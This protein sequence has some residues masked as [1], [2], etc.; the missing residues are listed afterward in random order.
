MIDFHV[1]IGK[2]FY[3][4][5]PLTPKKLIKRMNEKGIEKAV[6]LPIENP[7]ETHWY[8]TSENVLK[9]CKK[10][11]ERLIPFCNVDPRRGLNNENE[12]FIKNLIEEYAESG[13]KG[14]G[15]ILANLPFND[16]RM[17]NIYK[18][19]GE[20]KLPIVFHLGGVPGNST[21]GLTDEIGLPFIEEVLSEFPNTIFVAHGPGWWAEISGNVTPEERNT[22]PKGKIEKEGKVQYL[23]Q[24]YSNIYAD[25]S[26][27]SAYNALTRDPEYGIEFLNKFYDKLLFATDYLY[28]EQELPIIDYLKNI[29]L[30]EEKKKKIFYENA[31]KLLNI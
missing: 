22:Y 23:L 4:R 21:I 8:N 28:P 6:I 10:Y 5:K 3:G 26:A 1:H 14:F 11:R 31:K 27:G 17:K 2:I 20:L 25:L 7:E 13:A 15:E 30:N 16:K 24:N 29:N 9:I 12:K 19:C 18:I